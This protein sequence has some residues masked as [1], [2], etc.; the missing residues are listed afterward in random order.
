MTDGEKKKAG[1]EK[2]ERLLVVHKTFVLLTGEEKTVFYLFSVDNVHNSV[3]NS[4]KWS[5]FE[6]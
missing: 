4:G 1:K 6:K 3:Q 2:R 5:F